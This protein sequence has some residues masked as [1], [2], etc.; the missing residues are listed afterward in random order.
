MRHS[1]APSNHSA[2]D[3]KPR[4]LLQLSVAGKQG[5]V[6]KLHRFDLVL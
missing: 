2:V 3:H 1:K 6:L 5:L 4:T